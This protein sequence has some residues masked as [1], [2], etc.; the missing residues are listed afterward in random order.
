MADL[1]QDEA[2]SLIAMRKVRENDDQHIYPILQRTLVVPLISEDRRES[3][4]LDLHAG[5]IKLS[6]ATIQNR[7][8]QVIVLVRL[9]LDGAPHRNPDGEE[10]PCPHLHIYRVG[11]A[12]KWAIPSPTDRFSNLTDRWQTLIDFMDYCTIVD[13]P[14]FQRGLLP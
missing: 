9:D 1:T 5:K 14:K 11:F 12:D 6:K 2:D 7:A 13:P 8:R 3:F 10:I 4:S